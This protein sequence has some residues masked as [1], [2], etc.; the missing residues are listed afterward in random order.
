MVEKKRAQESFVRVINAFGHQTRQ[1][2]NGTWDTNK[3]RQRT[4]CCWIN[5]HRNAVPNIVLAKRITRYRNIIHLKYRSVN[6]TA[7]AGF[8]KFSRFLLLTYRGCCCFFSLLFLHHLKL[9]GCKMVLFAP[10][11]AHSTSKTKSIE[12][13]KKCWRNLLRCGSF[14]NLRL[15]EKSYAHEI[16]RDRKKQQQGIRTYRFWCWIWCENAIKSRWQTLTENELI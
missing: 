3:E 12:S 5:R 8:D 15:H 14:K 7:R 11:H 13:N 9:F 6:R 10:K 2:C 4:R 16:K 1:E